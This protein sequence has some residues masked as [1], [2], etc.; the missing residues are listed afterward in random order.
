VTRGKFR[1]GALLGAAYTVTRTGPR[2][3]PFV[4]LLAATSVASVAG[5]ATGDVD[6]S[7]AVRVA[8]TLTA[9]GAVPLGATQRAASYYKKK[10]LACHGATGAGDGPG[11][12]KLDPKPKSFRDASWQ[13]ANS[14]ERIKKVTVEGG[15]ANG[16]TPGMPAHLDLRD[17][18]EVQDALVALIRSFRDG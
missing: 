6:A 13:C 5:T 3:G 9:A 1:C 18:P 8:P 12:A 2:L 17:A 16:M 14:D 11:A 10:C 7:R 15:P 4:A